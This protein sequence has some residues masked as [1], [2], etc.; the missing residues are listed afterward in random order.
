MGQQISTTVVVFGTAWTMHGRTRMIF[1]MVGSSGIES[2]CGKLQEPGTRERNARKSQII[3]SARTEIRHRSPAGWYQVGT[4]SLI[5]KDLK[6]PAP[7]NF[8]KRLEGEK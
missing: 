3:G 7:V 1:E 5:R 4:P 2:I 8:P 6:T